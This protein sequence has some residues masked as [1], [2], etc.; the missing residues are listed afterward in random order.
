MR[1]HPQ[2][3]W[4]FFETATGW[5]DL[6]FMGLPLGIVCMFFAVSRG[7]CQAIFGSSEKRP[8]SALRC[9]SKSLRRK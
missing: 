3:T 6:T 9:I 4:R 2:G 7:L 1:H 8:I 5:R